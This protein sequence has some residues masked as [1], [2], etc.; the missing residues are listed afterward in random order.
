MNLTNKSFITLEDLNL[1][2]FREIQAIAEV[3]NS[4][5]FILSG[6]NSPK[7]LFKSISN[8]LRYFNQSTFLMSDERI[9]DSEDPNSNEG[10]FLRLSNV[11][12]ENLISLRDK[13]IIQKLKRIRSF[14]LSVLGMGM[15]GHFASIFPG[16]INTS[17]ALNSDQSIISFEDKHLNFMRISLSLN[18]ILKSKKI[19]LIASSINKQSLLNVKS[20]LPVY[21]LL[22]KASNKLSVYSCD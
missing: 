22:N 13:K 9:I 4:P 5:C 7:Y 16:C 8:N 17:R 14:D 10:E 1:E 18:E 15:D 12:N 21:Q 2:I 11:P 20:D 19:I 3:K 6:G